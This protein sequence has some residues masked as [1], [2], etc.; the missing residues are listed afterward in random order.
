M[1]IVY[2]LNTAGK[3]TCCRPSQGAEAQRSQHDARQRRRRAAG[4][5]STAATTASPR[6]T[7]ILFTG[8]L[9]P[10]GTCGTACAA[11][12][13][14]TVNGRTSSTPSSSLTVLGPT[15]LEVRAVHAFVSDWADW[16]GKAACRRA[17]WDLLSSRSWRPSTLLESSFRTVA[18]RQL[19]ALYLLQEKRWP[20]SRRT[21][22]C[23]FQRPC[24]TERYYPLPRADALRRTS[25]PPEY[26]YIGYLGSIFRQDAELMAQALTASTP[27]ARRLR[28]VVVGAAPVISAAWCKPRPPSST[29]VTWTAAVNAPTFSCDV[30]RCRCATAP[31]I[32]RCTPTRSFND[33]M[34][35]VRPTT[36]AVG[37]MPALAQERI[38]CVAARRC[39]T[40]PQGRHPC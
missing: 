24:I 15:Y 26:Q 22:S 6:E 4:E 29:P 8:S 23:F 28:L 14:R 19:P 36:T 2:L 40:S 17:P 21:P 35:A 20:D 33:Y 5:I 34:L 13:G 25:L 7:P 3:G 12:P 16:F 18:G 27:S 10:A 1:N 11:S 39:A 9:R 31:P 30:L 37:D 38:G 32:A